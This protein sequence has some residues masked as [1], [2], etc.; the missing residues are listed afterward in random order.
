MR[1][2]RGRLEV[3]SLGQPPAQVVE[4][5]GAQQHRA[6]AAGPWGLDGIPEG[7]GSERSKRRSAPPHRGSPCARA[8]IGRQ[9][10]ARLLNAVG[11][12]VSWNP[13]Q[14]RDVAGE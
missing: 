11:E 3:P 9:K 2:V 13:G 5:G 4:I 1:V 7:S 6:E 10:Q 8:G 14:R 12:R